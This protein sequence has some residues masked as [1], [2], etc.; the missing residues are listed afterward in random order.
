MTDLTHTEQ[1]LRGLETATKTV[2]KGDIS[3]EAAEPLLKALREFNG[4]RP[5]SRMSTK[6]SADALYELSDAKSGR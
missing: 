5:A 1:L 3:P 6:Q 2:Q 4:E